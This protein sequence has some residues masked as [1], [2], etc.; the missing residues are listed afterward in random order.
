MERIEQLLE[1]LTKFA[2]V[3]VI[4]PDDPRYPNARLIYNRMHDDY[5]ALIVRT[6]TVDAIR[7]ILAFVAEEQVV[8]AIRGGGHHIGGFGT[9]HQGIV[10]DFSVFKGIEIDHEQQLVSVE[11]GCCLGELDA[12]LSAAGYIVP[13]GTVSETGLAGLTLG[14]GIGWLIGQYGLTCDQLVGADVL[15]A[16]GRMV[17]AEDPEHRQLLWALRGGGGNFGIVL[18]F[19]YQLHPLPTTHC[20]MGLVDWEHC[21]SV[22]RVLLP[23]L[24]D[25]CPSSMT[26]APIFV[27]NDRGES[28]LRI[29]FCCANGTT[30]DVLQLMSLSKH[31]HWTAVKEWNFV[32]WQRAFDQAFL[33]PMRGYWKAVYLDTL[34]IA[35]IETLCE[36]FLQSSSP[37]CSILIEHL[38]GAFKHRDQDSSA[39]PLRDKN[40]GILFSLRWEAADEDA[41]QIRW[42]KESFSKIDPMGISSTYVNYTN[43]DDKRAVNTLLLSS[44]SAIAEVKALYDPTNLFRRNHNVKP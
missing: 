8:L 40:F 21:L 26:V 28:H 11:P 12:T 29:D 41:E 36:V 14:G 19:R 25:Q 2:S 38:H 24:N 7:S 43:A 3:D 13:T 1:R 27:K 18:K 17:K 44:L 6:L 42:V 31:I 15:L 5:P 33:P 10:L 39:F 37:R 4:A 34:S 32:E 23:Y 22:M 35:I 20:G 9:C 16:D 30:D